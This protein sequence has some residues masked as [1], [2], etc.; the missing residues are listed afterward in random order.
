MILGLEVPS[1]R[2]YLQLG[3]IVWVWLMFSGVLE[4]K[5][6]PGLSLTG[7]NSCHQPLALASRTDPVIKS[8][9]LISVDCSRGMAWNGCSVHQECPEV[10]TVAIQHWTIADDMI[11]LYIHVGFVIAQGAICGNSARLRG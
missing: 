10:P 5:V 8:T 11:S 4:T 3:T 2:K 7:I 9:L 1:A 6:S